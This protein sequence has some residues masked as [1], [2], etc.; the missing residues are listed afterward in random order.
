MGQGVKG[1]AVAAAGLGV[2][3][4]RRVVT[5]ARGQNGWPMPAS[6]DGDGAGGAP[7]WHAVTVYR[8]RDELAPSGQ[9]PPPLAELGDRVEVRLT[10][11]PG[12][13]GTEIHAR[14]AGGE[15][16]RDL[17]RQ[18]RAALRTSKQL[19]EAGEVL[20]PDRPGTTRA[21]PLNAALRSA[22]AHG[23]EEGRL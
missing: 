3:A 17:T 9:L 14:A 19:A 1:A 22:T 8:G 18:I 21:T 15:A 23:L 12:D 13:R 16:D 6:G 4:A 5:L 7:R 11:A 10:E 20:Q 2:L